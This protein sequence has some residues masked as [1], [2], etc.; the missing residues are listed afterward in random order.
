MNRAG[1]RLRTGKTNVISLVLNTE[2]QIMEHGDAWVAVTMPGALSGV[3][4]FNPTRYADLSFANP[5]ACPA[6]ANGAAE[7]EDG[8]KWDAL[9]QVAAA[10]KKKAV[11]GLNAQYV[12]MM[13]QGEMRAFGHAKR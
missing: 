3:K 8:L 6:G 7:V 10:L 1:V 13:T 4:K 11:P 9:S 12:F 5:G 2:E